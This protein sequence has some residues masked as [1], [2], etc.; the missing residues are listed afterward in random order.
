MD[1]LASIFFV[2]KGERKGSQIKSSSTGNQLMS[3]KRKFSRT[4]TEPDLRPFLE[5]EGRDEKPSEPEAIG[6]GA[7][8]RVDSQTKSE[9]GA[10]P[11]HSELHS[12]HA[13]HHPKKSRSKCYLIVF[14]FAVL[15]A[16]FT[17]FLGDAAQK[18]QADVIPRGMLV[19]GDSNRPGLHFHQELKSMNRTVKPFRPVIMIPGFVT[20][21]LELWKMQ[22]CLQGVI[23]NTFRARMFSTSLLVELLRN[24]ECY[25]RH[26]A[27]GEDGGD[28][29]ENIRVRPSEGFDSAD[30]IVPTYWVWAKILINLADIG[31]DSR[32]MH[33]AS[34]DWRL[35]PDLMERRDGFFSALKFKLE[36]FLNRF[37]KPTVVITHSYGALIFT[38]FLKWIVQVEGSEE[39]GRRWIDTHVS[40]FFN[41][42]GPLLGIPKAL[43][44]MMSGEFR[45]TANLPTQLQ[46]ALNLH[47]PLM[48]RASTFRTWSC[49]QAMLPTFSPA[50]KKLVTFRNP[51]CEQ[52]VM[53]AASVGEDSREAESSKRG[54]DRTLSYEDALKRLRTSQVNRPHPGM[55][56]F[57][58]RLLTKDGASNLYPHYTPP[59]FGAGKLASFR[60]WCAHGV[61]YKSE[62]GYFYR[63]SSENKGNESE[64]TQFL[65]VDTDAPRS[66]VQEGNGDATVPLESLAYMCFSKKR[67][68]KTVVASESQVKLIQIKNPAVGNALESPPLLSSTRDRLDIR[69]GDKTGDH[70]DI[71]GNSEIIL[72]ILQIV[73]GHE[74]LVTERIRTEELGKM[75]AALD[76]AQ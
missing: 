9:I 46:M 68:W 67:G 34:F 8:R 59:T 53:T 36:H 6:Q 35:S 29:E 31:V 30:Y 21:Q 64:E 65:E 40:D 32:M 50:W 45:D 42:G 73:S 26:M 74:D 7:P 58:D 19:E 72:A 52:S 3:P 43:A 76:L 37:Q 62:V 33:M 22:D 2:T 11:A 15:I 55:E 44:A 27:L 75:T 13:Q 24:P 60:V 69:G 54:C 70:V 4:R 16:F 47:V 17:H 56:A 48:S 5:A 71:M 12:S 28:P 49:L 14:V 20:T 38:D 51:S 18:L 57:V 61:D 63:V 25:L 1:N 41:I 10:H 39:K 23:T 66:G